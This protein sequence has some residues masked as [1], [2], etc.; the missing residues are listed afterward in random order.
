MT[1]SVHLLQRVAAVIDGV[2]EYIGRA[3]SWLTLAMVMVTFTIVVLR[4]LFNVG[5]IAV[6]E[7]VLYMHAAV[8]LLSLIHI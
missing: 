1:Q 4:Y 7:S 6:Q 5:W 2:N 3:V 8:F